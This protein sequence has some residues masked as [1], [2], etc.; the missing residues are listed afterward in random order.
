MSSIDWDRVSA[1]LERTGHRCISQPYGLPSIG[2]PMQSAFF[3]EEI[4]PRWDIPSDLIVEVAITGAF[5]RPSENP[6]Q[7]LTVEDIRGQA[8]ECVDAG[9]SAIHIHVRDDDGYNVLDPERFK[10]VIEPLRENNSDLFVDGCLVC[11]LDGEW[12]KM[13]QVMNEGTLDGCPINPTATFVGDTLFAKP[14]PMILEKTRLILESGSTVQIAV[15]TDGD[16]ANADRYLYRSGLLEPGQTWLILPALPGCSPMANPRQMADG[17]LR[18]SSAI[19]DTD[20]EATVIVCAAGR[21]SLYLATMAATLGLHVRVGMED[22]CWVW[23]HRDELI[24][25][26]LQVLELTKM[27]AAG[28]GR[29]VATPARYREIVGAPARSAT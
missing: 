8:Q 10:E 17:L 5:M 23:P 14:A 1:G 19:Y 7:P 11:S 16:V 25:S 27:I 28:L 2:S 21:A 12:E 9:A 24:Q 6:N 15:Y 26:N 4:S 20:P 3:D 29:E 18:L 13:K 22:T